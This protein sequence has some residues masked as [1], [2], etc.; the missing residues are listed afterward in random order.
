MNFFRPY[1][2]NLMPSL[3]KIC[4]RRDEESVQETLAVA[5]SKLMPVLGQFTN[6]KEVK[7]SIFLGVT[8]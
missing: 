4:Q 5:I 7:V 1:T 2:V 8:Y 3:A 6:D